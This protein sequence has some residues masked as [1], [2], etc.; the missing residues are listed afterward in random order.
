MD[1]YAEFKRITT[2][3]IDTDVLIPFVGRTENVDPDI[4]S[5]ENLTAGKKYYNVLEVSKSLGKD[6]CLA[7]LF[8]Y[9]SLIHI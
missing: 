6:A 8:F 5:Y 1:N 9:L 3:T 2:N 4:E 7:I